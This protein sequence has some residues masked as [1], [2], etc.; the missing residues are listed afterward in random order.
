MLRRSALPFIIYA[1]LLCSSARAQ[2]APEHF[3]EAEAFFNNKLTLTNRLVFQNAMIAAGYLNAVP[4]DR[5]SLRLFRGIERFQRE[6]TLPVTGVLEMTSADGVL[7]SAATMFRL[8]RL[9]RLSHPTR[10]HSIL[11]PTGMGLE[12]QPNEFGIAYAAP[13]GK[14]RVRYNHFPNTSAAENY[15]ELTAKYQRTNVRVNFRTF[16]DGWF[17]ISTT[18]PGGVDGYL[19]YHTDGDGITGF[20]L[21]WDNQKGNVAGERVATLMSASLWAQMTGAP[22]V[23]PPSGVA[24]VATREQAPAN[25][26]LEPR[27]VPVSPASPPVEQ[28]PIA[29]AKISTGTGFF[30]SSDGLLATN[31]HVIEACSSINV[32]T[33][34]RKLR[35]ARLVASDATND[36][37][38]L[39]LEATPKLFAVLRPSARLGEDVSAFG[40]PHTDLFATTGNFSTGGITA[41]SG[42]GDD[43]RYFQIS[44]PVHA[45]NSGGPLLDDRGNVVGVVTSKLNSLKFAARNGGE[46]PQNVNFALKAS[47]LTSFLEGNGAAVTTSKPDAPRLERPDV[48]ELA[49]QISAFIACQ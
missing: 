18:S 26:P 34:D 37:A 38:L 19:R 24:Q 47:L 1:L 28:K 40:F 36:L 16:K 27:P 43:T 13:D 11:L 44:A 6:N 32:Q 15:A 33:A 21:F 25:L 46:V 2:E 22:F 9:Q 48:A 8:W 14:L 3:R 45:G 4:T 39:K 23:D 35:P 42:L 17:V 30:L 49:R 20:A 41:S 5:F 31:H 29:P 7:A 12:L 10:R